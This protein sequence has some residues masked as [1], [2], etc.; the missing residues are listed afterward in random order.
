[1]NEFLEAGYKPADFERFVEQPTSQMKGRGEFARDRARVLHSAAFRKLSAK[2]QVLSPTSGDFARTRL[3]HS[4]EVAQVGRELANSLGVN[5]DL[6]DMGCLAHDLGHPPF[7]HNGEAA[8][9]FW[10]A[11]IGGFEGNAQTFRILTRLEPK[12]YDQSGISRGLNLTRA[13]LDAAT[14][15][16]WQLSRAAEFGSTTKF[17]VY[18]DDL[19]VFGWMRH[20]A[21]DGAKCVEAQIMDFADDVAYSVHDFEDSI[22]E[23]FVIAAE[24]SDSN[25]D[26][27]LIDDISKWSGGTLARVQLEEALASLR[28]SK[29]WLHEFDGSPRHLAQLKNLASDIIGSFVSR[30]TQAILQNASK[31]SL[32]RYRAGVIVPSKVRSEIAVLKG[33]V[34]SSV[35]THN[36]RQPYYEDQRSLLIELAD[37]LFAKNGF[38]LDPQA[39]EAWGVAHS[40]HSKKRV[41]VDSVASLTDPAAIALHKATRA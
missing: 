9:N 26:E 20:G 21:P 29:Y 38:G 33:I 19:E 37:T 25:S 24:I 11:D 23:G 27:A 30:T 6:V 4:L 40:D 15:Y 22:V 5:P 18:E 14:K 3:T 41:I 10:A 32:T 12:I 34:A 39:T 16:P 28:T 36:S 1:M 13:S 31:N 35:M 7:G 8:L 2:T 17:G